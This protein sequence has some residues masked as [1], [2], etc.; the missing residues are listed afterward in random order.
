MRSVA[1]SVV[2]VLQHA[3]PIYVKIGQI[4]STRDDLLPPVIC[5]HLAKLYED[6]PSVMSP[7]EVKA[8]LERSYPAGLPFVEFE[9]EPFGVG[10]VAQVHRATL[11]NG[12]RVAVKVLKPGLEETVGRDVA[13]AKLLVSLVFK[14]MGSK[15]QT[16]VHAVNELI[17]D[18]GESFRY[19]FD[20]E[21]EAVNLLEFRR[22]LENQKNVLIP[23]A[24]PGHSTRSV[25]VMD[26]VPGLPLNKLRHNAMLS[27]ELSRKVAKLA[28][29]EV[30]KQVLEVGVF[31]PDPHGGNLILTPDDRLGMI[32]LAQAARFD[33]ED[34][35]EL[36]KVIQSIVLR[37]SEKITRAFLNFGESPEDFDAEI[38]KRDVQI[39]V[40]KNEP[41]G[42]FAGHVLAV[43]TRHKVTMNAETVA[44]VRCLMTVEALSRSL[45]PN[46]SVTKTAIPTVITS[47][48][49][50]KF[51]SK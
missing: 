21:R 27:P 25:L 16:W 46:F 38:L 41:L 8:Q 35:K 43:V 12:Q 40:D 32:D 39:E 19:E 6:D 11:E 7:A 47:Y 22:K 48:L 23:Q 15:A 4:L 28:L 24:Y 37:D 36:I 3:G 49:K 14:S 9:D 31:H 2:R 5:E 18:I 13:S 17:E 26:E 42:R 44:L 30:L 29:Q 50:S 51:L 20:L 1:E 33:S 45:D 10:L 34:K